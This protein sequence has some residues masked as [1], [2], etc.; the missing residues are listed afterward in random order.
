M[1]LLRVLAGLVVLTV[2]CAAS[3][4][5][6]GVFNKSVTTSYEMEVDSPVEE[7]FEAF[8]DVDRL[9]EWASSVKS[10]ELISGKRREVGA[11]Y[12]LVINRH[13]E[14]LE[15]IEE[16]TEFKQNEVFGY[17]LEGKDIC[18]NNRITFRVENGQ[19]LVT[20]TTVTRGKHA[21][22]K[23]MLPFKTKSMETRRKTSYDKLKAM[24][25]NSF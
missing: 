25:E 19:T 5:L 22:A 4:W 17:K 8:L 10:V 7:V 18:S 16:I 12:K 13:G 6:I 2:L 20:G 11:K 9:S 21:I 1:K 3:F 15:F 24:V 23:S 14:D